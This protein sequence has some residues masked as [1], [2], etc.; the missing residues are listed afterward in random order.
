MTCSHLAVGFSTYFIFA[1]LTSS[2]EK[3]SAASLF[4]SRLFGAAQV[5]ALDRRV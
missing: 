2:T 1:R 3:Q 5:W 4:L